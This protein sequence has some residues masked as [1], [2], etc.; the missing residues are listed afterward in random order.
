MEKGTNIQVIVRCRGRNEREQR[1][2]LPTVVSVPPISG[3]QVSVKTSAADVTQRRTY[4]FDRVFGPDATQEN[5]F[6]EV[7]MPL[8]EEVTKGYN[9]TL[10]A[11][12]QTGT[13]KTYTMEGDLEGTQGQLCDQSGIIPR[14]LYHLF[15]HL[16]RRKS[17][18][19]VMVSYIELYNEE[20]RDLLPLDEDETPQR[21][22]IYDDTS[23][24]A[25]KRSILIQGLQEL[26]VENARDALALLQKGS[27][28][29]CVAAT[30]CNEKSSRSHAIFSITVHITESS[31]ENQ[32]LVKIGKLNLVDLAGSENIGRSGAENK[33]VREAGKINQSLLTLGRVIN[34]L[35]K[36]ASYI[37]YRDSNLT[38]LLQDSLGGHTKTSII[39]TVAPTR[40]D[41]EETLS[42]LEYAN[43]AKNIKNKP[44]VN[45]RVT[46]NTLVKEFERESG[47]LKNEI[48]RL[49]ADLLASREKNGIHLTKNSYD[50]LLEENQTCKDA[51]VEYKL[52]MEEMEGSVQAANE[53]TQDIMAQLRRAT[54]DLEAV[55]ARLRQADDRLATA[56]INL[57]RARVTITEQ[58][59]VV[60]AH[61]RT[62]MQL[63]DVAGDLLACVQD[64]VDDLT[65]L[66]NVADDHHATDTANRTYL[67]AFEADLRERTDAMVQEV[68]DYQQVQTEFLGSFA[69]GLEMTYQ[70]EQ[71]RLRDHL[72]TL[73]T[74]CEDVLAGQADWAASY[75]HH[76]D[77]AQTERE[78][79]AHTLIEVERA[80]TET[81]TSLRSGL[82]AALRTLTEQLTVQRTEFGDRLT[83]LADAVGT[84]LDQIRHLVTDQG[85]KADRLDIDTE[86]ALT[87]SLTGGEQ[88]TADLTSV[89]EE[90]GA[91][92]ERRKEALL[93]EVSGLLAA[94]FAG[95]RETLVRRLSQ[96]QS[97]EQTQR[98]QLATFRTDH[99]TAVAELRTISGV[100]DDR[101]TA[102]Q[103]RLAADAA[104]IRTQL[105]DGTTA[106]L[107]AHQALLT[108]RVATNWDRHSQSLPTALGQIS[109]AQAE[110]AD[111]DQR[112][113]IA[114]QAS[115]N[116]VRTRLAK[117]AADAAACTDATTATL[118]TSG[119]YVR[120]QTGHLHEAFDAFAANAQD[121]MH[122]LTARTHHLVHT[123]VRPL[124]DSDSAPKRRRFSYTTTWAR[125]AEPETL[126]AEY[127]EARGEERPI[128]LTAE[129]VIRLLAAPSSPD[130]SPLLL[131]RTL[132][133]LS[134]HLPTDD[135]NDDHGRD[136]PDSLGD[137]RGDPRAQRLARSASALS[138]RSEDQLTV[139]P[140][141]FVSCATAIPL[142]DSVSESGSDVEGTTPT[143]AIT[144]TSGAHPA[145]ATPMNAQGT[146]TRTT[147]RAPSR[148]G[149]GRTTRATRAVSASAMSVTAAAKIPLP[150]SPLINSTNHSATRYGRTVPL[151]KMVVDGHGPADIAGD[152]KLPKRTRRVRGE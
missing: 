117:A 92:C 120:C 51:V 152:T 128:N 22:R 59:T 88:L 96:V 81:D 97:M 105:A 103:S 148:L 85:K 6:Q 122:K 55:K 141:R 31:P 63:D 98:A 108:A 73:R 132:S 68:K 67:T 111:R 75:D 45:Q 39:A 145:V 2:A 24:D 125:T 91:E 79:T 83:G 9:C 107:D 69:A 18:F 115:V 150:K 74:Q 146:T 53:R 46:Q 40:A 90:H 130:V 131:S 94:S 84:S 70:T 47:R 37:P 139:L 87:A 50:E 34:E 54:E 102:A 64:A 48:V 25:A 61:S 151:S 112:Q 35:V 7:A 142:P 26:P 109:A 77:I 144:T 114:A 80:L 60:A 123:Q 5:L 66:H 32:G 95:Q 58:L 86:T 129:D 99:R 118:D 124:P 149:S 78:R 93:N 41:L 42:T 137:T 133:P 14:T 136:T 72:A 116:T 4:M 23:K 71:A 104:A 49:R 135:S 10:F 27:H 147:V 44:E 12:G 143:N 8:I 33:R 106:V 13:G 21:L 29:R 36:H 65:R 119:T 89:L 82:E 20:L 121:R 134:D 140:K 126:L 11:Y 30:L 56:A 57:E 138:L 110:A 113:R 101:A 1:E 127:Y 19:T 52:R 38:R 62:E 16:G 3:R 43:R 17:D 76:G 100:I 28:R 15:E